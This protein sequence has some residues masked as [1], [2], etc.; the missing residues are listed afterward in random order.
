M[1]A[2]VDWVLSGRTW[3]TQSPVID[4]GA[5]DVTASL[6]GLYL[7]HPT[8][9]LDMLAR[10]VVAMTAAGVA[11]PAA[12]ITEARYVRLTSSGVFTIDWTGATVLRDLLGFAGNLAAASSYTATLRSP[13]LW[14]AGKVLTPGLAPLGSHGQKVLDISATF[15][16]GGN[17]TVRQEGSATVL[18][19]FSAMHVPKARYFSAPPTYGA[20]EFTGF[21][22]TELTTAKKFHVMRA[23]TEGP[24]TTATAVYNS[25]TAG[26]LLGPYVADMSDAA[27]RRT[28]FARSTGFTLVEAYYDCSI[29]AVAT[30]QFA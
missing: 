10:L 27:F 24:S 7:V 18:N 11:A 5:E 16:A 8:A 14:S 20:G 6:G 23:V 9:A 29:P 21:W 4:G 28:P 1:A 19:R 13:L 17:L 3:V 25:G 22:E 12:F 26:H 2:S 15:G 30:A